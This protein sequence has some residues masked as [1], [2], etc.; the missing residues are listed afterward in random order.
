MSDTFYMWLSIGCA[1]W[2][3][4]CLANLLRLKA[5]RRRSPKT[6]L[7]VASGPVMSGTNSI[8]VGHNNTATESPLV[9]DAFGIIRER[10]IVNSSPNH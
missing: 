10:Q 8:A 6:A 7:A 3:I 2:C 5:R 4:G 9:L 1:V